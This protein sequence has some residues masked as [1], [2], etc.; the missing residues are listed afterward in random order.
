MYNS[1]KRPLE[2]LVEEVTSIWSCTSEGCKGWMRD[3][4]SFSNEPT[5]PQCNSP[6]EKGER[7]LSVLVNTSPNQNKK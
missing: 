7:M 3:N 2:E 5:C 4:F 1:R 6:M